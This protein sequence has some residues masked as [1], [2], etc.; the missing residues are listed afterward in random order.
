[1]TE[2][3]YVY[4]DIV[5]V[6]N[7]VMDYTILWAT[8]KLGQL[9]AP[10]RRLF[11]GALIGACYSAVLLFPNFSYMYSLLVRLL[12]SLIIV[13]VTFAPLKLTKLAQ[14]LIYFYL[15]AFTMG[16]AILG[17][18]YFLSNNPHLY[19]TMNEL[20]LSLVN[21]KYT[22]LLVGV[23]VA[24]VLAKLGVGFIKKNLL[25]NYL[26]VPVTICL[27]SHRLEVEALL[28]TGNQLKDPITQAPVLIAELRVLAPVMPRD[29][30]EVFQHSTDPEVHKMIAKLAHSSWSSRLRVIPF[31]SIGKHHGMLLGLRP[32]EVI[33]RTN[34]RTVRTKNVVIGVYNKAL[35]PKGSYQALLHPDLIESAMSA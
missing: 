30:Q 1:M 9:Q 20:M 12:L 8:A 6:I 25:K 7:L 28:D 35:C 21:I 33:V 34:E 5:F 23:A 13:G 15:I 19:G 4:I 14:A 11:L 27:A 32:D 26:R 29:I 31:T 2:Q 16:G 3:P 24:V 10:K 22:W 17:G 18:I